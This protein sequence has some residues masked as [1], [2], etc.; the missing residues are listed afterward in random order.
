MNDFCWKMKVYFKMKTKK[1]ITIVRAIN[2]D[3]NVLKDLIVKL[4]NFIVKRAR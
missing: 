2:N 4:E 1:P 3:E